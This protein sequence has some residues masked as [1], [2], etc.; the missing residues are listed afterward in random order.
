M[1]IVSISILIIL[2]LWNI[3][4]SYQNKKL[5]RYQI[6]YL[7]G[8]RKEILKQIEILNSDFKFQNYRLQYSLMGTQLYI[9]AIMDKAVEEERYEDAKT[10]RDV[11]NGIQEIMKK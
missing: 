3:G 9:K 8:M 2:L 1:L 10:L 4:V 5:M 7:H 6:L 11:L